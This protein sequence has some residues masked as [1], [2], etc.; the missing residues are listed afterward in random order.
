MFFLVRSDIWLKKVE[1]LLKIWSEGCCFCVQLVHFSGI[2][3]EI[4]DFN[5]S[6]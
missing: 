1:A 5:L 6:F 4:S 3:G 2:S